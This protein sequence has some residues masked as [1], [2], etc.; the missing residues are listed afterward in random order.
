[1]RYSLFTRLQRRIDHARASGP[2]APVSRSLFSRRPGRDT[3]L[4][5]Q[6]STVEAGS[7]WPVVPAQL[8]GIRDPHLASFEVRVAPYPNGDADHVLACRRTRAFS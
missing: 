5:A 2:H 3:V 6:H 8:Y 7:S 1:M 4:T